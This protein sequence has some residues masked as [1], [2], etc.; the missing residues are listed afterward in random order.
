MLGLA[1]LAGIIGTGCGTSF[2]YPPAP[3]P[4]DASA[5]GA[6][7]QRTMTLLATSTPNH[8]NRVKILFYGQSITEQKWT[9]LVSDWLRKA[10]PHA[11]L[12]IEN[13]A[14]GG[15]SSQL[16]W[17]TAEADLYPFQ[18]DLLIFHVYGSH[19]DYETIIANVKKRTSAEVLIQ[20]DHITKPE[21]MAEPSENPNPPMSNWSAWWNQLFL[22]DIA[23]RY[24]VE[25]LDQRT[26]WRRYLKEN[27][28]EPKQLLIDGVHLNDWGCELMAQLVE[29]HLRYMPTAP[30]TKWQ[31]LVKDFPAR[32]VGN[33][34][35]LAFDGNRVEA[36]A[37]SG[38]QTTARVLIDG[39]APA[40]FAFTRTSAYPNSNWPV[41]LRAV[42]QTQP[43]EE[44]WSARIWD[45]SE[46][47]KSF[48]FEVVGSRTGIDGEGVSTQKFVSKSGRV[49]IE[50]EDW[51]LAYCRAVFKTSIPKDLVVRWKCARQSVEEY[52]VS[53][54][55]EITTLV[56]GLPNGKHVLELVVDS[57]FKPNIK[58]LRV[59]RP[60]MK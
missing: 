46:D 36:V 22:P 53:N 19:I 38:S 34:L 47:G 59:Y 18:P 13:R 45:A 50:P 43:L 42:S 25:L 7:I 37:G 1:F 48:K 58:A 54:D 28:L 3:I 52:R 57:G 55:G 39:K 20:S 33:K 49:A 4:T 35:R 23:K 16:L 32:W 17:R 2:P 26:L 11:N 8:R 10:Y 24:D 5:F 40:T 31:S 6:G 30:K 14:I 41:L 27:K 51:N 21:E 15:H 56:Q 60:P 29:Q 12:I 9:N 44:E